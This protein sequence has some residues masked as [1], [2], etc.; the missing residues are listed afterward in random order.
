[1]IDNKNREETEEQKLLETER[2]KWLNFHKK[3]YKD[4]LE[5]SKLLLL[6]H[7]R[8][9]I[10]A[11]YYA[12]HDLAKYYL[13]K[14]HNLKI[15]PPDAHKKTINA[16]RE[17]LRD[18]PDKDRIIELLESAKDEFESI[19]K[20]GEKAPNILLK[21]GKQ[22]RSKV[23]YY[24]ETEQDSQFQFSFSQTASFFS[25]NIVKP[26]VKIMEHLLKPKKEDKKEKQDQN[27]S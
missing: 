17:K 25:E 21:Q 18:H 8:W 12:M 9:S 6:K 10:I 23:Q 3:A 14:T 19:L 27:A 2:E 4:D 16:L 7:P 22:Q 13:G 1:M 15:A 20:F 11:N 24:S 5:A 26:F